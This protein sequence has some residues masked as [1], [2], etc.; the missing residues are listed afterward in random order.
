MKFRVK[1]FLATFNGSAWIQE[2]IDSILRQVG[3]DVQVYVS[4]DFSSDTTIA[5]LEG[6]TKQESRIELLPRTVIFGGAGKNFYRLILDVDLNDCDYVAFA[7]QDDI[8]EQDK[9]IRH[10]GLMQQS[11]VDAVSSNVIAFWPNGKTK[12]IDKAQPQRELDYL[13]ESAGPGCTFL[14]TSQLVGLVKKLLSDPGGIANKVALHDWLV[15]AVCRISGRKWLIDSTPSL[16]Y[17]QH[18]KNVVGANIGLKAKFS[19][20]RK[21]SNGWYKAEVLK[22]LAVSFQLSN[23]PKLLTI[24]GLLEKSDLLSRLKLLRFVPQARRKLSDR[25][26]LGLM[27]VFDLF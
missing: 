26:I 5:L 21:I 10:I 11:G 9:L 12:L 1:V 25:F 16:Q 7:D 27:I 4:D 14:M 17:R 24:S 19:R 18:E 6:L 20:L 3:V 2:Q 8:W 22:I 15:Y 23:N 13:F